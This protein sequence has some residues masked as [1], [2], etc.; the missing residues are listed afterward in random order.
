MYE[1]Q[2]EELKPE[3]IEKMTAKEKEEHEKSIQKKKERYEKKQ[4]FIQEQEA[5]K[6]ADE[7]A[8]LKA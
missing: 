7:E 8:R 5:K 2:I 4:K 6:A 3:D 1:V